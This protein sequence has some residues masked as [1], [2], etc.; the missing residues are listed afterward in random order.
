MELREYSYT[1]NGH[2]LCFR[3]GQYL[4]FM[5][6]N[7][8]L[9]IMIIHSIEKDRYKNQDR[10]T[11]RVRKDKDSEIIDWKVIYRGEDGSLTIEVYDYEKEL[12]R[13]K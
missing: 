12:G 3:V 5:S 11:I 10:I 1:D 13:D 6:E 9:T 4:K 8:D 7:G 2:K